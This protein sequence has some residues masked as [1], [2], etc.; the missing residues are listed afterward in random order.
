MVAPVSEWVDWHRQY[1]GDAGMLQRL[2]LV[3]AAL[4]EALRSAPRPLRL[5]SMCAG[6]GRDVLEV[7]ESHQ[8]RGEVQARLVE[9]DVTLAG[10]ARE[11]ASAARLAI[12]VMETD[13]G[14]GD[15]YDGA[16]PADIALVCGVFGNITDD[17]VRNTIDHLPEL[18]AA[19]ATVIWTRGRFAPDLTPAIRGWFRGA[20]FEELSFT[21]IADSTATV[22]VHRLA[23][24]PRAFRRGV[25]LFSFLPRE[26]RPAQLART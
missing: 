24:P 1:D 19:N 25:R 11:R 3:Q 23:A 5:I 20:G 8:D 4:R 10:A 6:D 14:R 16:V 13:A 22:G 2:R 17:D 12:D 21:A 18:C 7:L 15:A 9:T 26:E